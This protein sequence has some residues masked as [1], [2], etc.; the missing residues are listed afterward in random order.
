LVALDSE[1]HIVLEDEPAWAVFRA[2]VERFLTSDRLAAPGQTESASASPPLGELLSAR[3]LEVLRLAAE[4]RDNSE[5]A[6]R[7]QL[8]VRTVERHL[9]NVYGKLELRGPSARVAA[10]ARML[11]ST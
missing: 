8:S 1:N 5:I 10:A 2:E 6:A 7:L 11:A 3:E 4:G 9:Q